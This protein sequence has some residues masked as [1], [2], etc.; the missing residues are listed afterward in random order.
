MVWQNKTWI[1]VRVKDEIFDEGKHL[2]VDFGKGAN[3]VDHPQRVKASVEWVR[4]GQ[5]AGFRWK[6]NDYGDVSV[7]YYFDGQDAP[8]LF[9]FNNPEIGRPTIEC[10][11][12]GSSSGTREMDYQV[13]TEYTFEGRKYSWLRT[14]DQFE[15]IG[16]Q[17]VVSK[18]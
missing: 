8:P 4:H 13:T 9:I 3:I 14:S 18:A 7:A 17:G 2:H 11:Y 6:Q 5:W 1:E 10:Y 12:K 16:F 15:A